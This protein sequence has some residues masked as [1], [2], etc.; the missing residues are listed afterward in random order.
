[1]VMWYI[2]LEVGTEIYMLEEKNSQSTTAQV[3]DSNQEN[4]E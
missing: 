2:F 4:N 3:K 1:M